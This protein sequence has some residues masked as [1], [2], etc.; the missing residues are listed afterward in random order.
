MNKN[1]A[2]LNNKP[3]EIT[4]SPNEHNIYVKYEDGSEFVMIG[5]VYYKLSSLKYLIEILKDVISISEM[6]KEEI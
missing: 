1:Y 2:Y 5:E 3:T 4:F 6:S